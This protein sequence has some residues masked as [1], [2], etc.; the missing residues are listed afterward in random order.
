LFTSAVSDPFALR[1]LICE[2]VDETGNGTTGLQSAKRETGVAMNDFAHHRREREMNG[3]RQKTAVKSP[4]SHRRLH[5]F[6]PGLAWLMAGFL[7]L[8]GMAG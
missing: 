4:T 6:T 5:I 7:R 3:K 8:A 2:A 1:N